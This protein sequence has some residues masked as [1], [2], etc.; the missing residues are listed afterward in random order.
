MWRGAW[1]AW[2]SPLAGAALDSAF[3]WK[4]QYGQYRDSETGL[5]Y[6]KARYYAPSLGRFISRDP[7]GFSGGI[8]LYAY[9]NDDPVNYA[10][11]LGRDGYFAQ[12]WGFFKGE[13]S[14]LNPVNMAKGLYGLEESCL[15]DYLDNGLRGKP[16]ADA[17]S[18]MGDS[19][20]FWNK[21]DAEQAGQGFMG[22]V[23][24]ATPAIKRIP[25]SFAS[26][27]ETMAIAEATSTPLTTV[28]YI[29]KAASV[30]INTML[31]PAEPMQVVEYISKGTSLDSI[32]G[33]LKELTYL[34]DVEHAV[35]RFSDGTRAIVSGGKY[36]IEFPPSV[37]R[38]IAHTHPYTLPPTGPSSADLSALGDLGQGS[39]YLLEHGDIT[40]FYK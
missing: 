40:K 31:G 21:D 29:Q 26:A 15:D 23:L 16:Y 37:T 28:A 9:C 4:G 27:T 25:L 38:L 14:A 11:P 24:I 35:V 12:A 19:L 8:N 13:C 5:V 18:K 36:G 34:N 33:T 17:I 7:I 32:A 10:D 2:G 39:S 30:C 6:C 22:C 1:S 20:A 3:G